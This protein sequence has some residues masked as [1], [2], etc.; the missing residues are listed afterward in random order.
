MQ[1]TRVVSE[2]FTVGKLE[3]TKHLIYNNIY[4][5]HVYCFP[6]GNKQVD[7]PQH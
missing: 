2:N 7:K 5:W 3:I 4:F 6:Y 1:K